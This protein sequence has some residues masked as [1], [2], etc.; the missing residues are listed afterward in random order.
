M[1]S[2]YGWLLPARMANELGDRKISI[3]R[4][5]IG[6]FPVRGR[7]HLF[8]QRIWLW[9]P[10]SPASQ[11][12]PNYIA[13]ICWYWHTHIAQQQPIIRMFEYWLQL[14]IPRFFGEAWATTCQQECYHLSIAWRDKFRAETWD[15]RVP[16]PAVGQKGEPQRFA[17][18]MGTRTSN[19]RG[20]GK[21]RWLCMLPQSPEW[22]FSGE[23]VAVLGVPCYH[24]LW[25]T[26][27]LLPLQDYARAGEV[28]WADALCQ[29]WVEWL[30][31]IVWGANLWVM[32]NY[33]ERQSSRYYP[34]QCCGLLA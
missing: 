7:R 17:I 33:G 29:K 19:G 14:D 15:M 4:Q 28:E 1:I 8:G 25:T 27:A 31:R 34:Y 30:G 11:K 26:L 3:T 12:W 20:R 24:P 23:K 18:A 5:V 13:D 32:A 21:E 6:G 22:S 16:P 2:H 10:G 9:V